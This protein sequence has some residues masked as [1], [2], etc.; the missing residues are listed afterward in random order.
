MRLALEHPHTAAV[1]CNVLIATMR[2]AH[3]DNKRVFYAYSNQKE[4]IHT[5]TRTAQRMDNLSSQTNVQRIERNE[6]KERNK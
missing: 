5:R 1:R 6:A 4:N 2:C 3:Y